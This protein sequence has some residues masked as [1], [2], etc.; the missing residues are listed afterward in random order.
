MA[1]SRPFSDTK[2][3]YVFTQKLY[4]TVLHVY[5]KSIQVTKI[6]D[7]VLPYDPYMNNIIYNCG[8]S[9]INP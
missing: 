4:Q 9:C 5:S 1:Q 3:Y 7:M 8:S 2:Q 6:I